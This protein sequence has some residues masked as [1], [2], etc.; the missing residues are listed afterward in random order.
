MSIRSAE[1]IRANLEGGATTND[2]DVTEDPRDQVTYT[3]NFEYTDTRGK[4]FAGRFTN[5]ALTVGEWRKVKTIKAHLA[6]GVPVSQQDQDVWEM[7]GRL[8]HLAVSLDYRAADF[9]IWAR[10][11]DDLFDEG[12]IIALYNEVASHEARFHRRI[13]PNKAGEGA[14]EDSAGPA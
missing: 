1:E 8:A 13:P 2:V 6:D 12:V 10:K 11:L 7:N 4:R 3:F 14:D 9:P 5:K